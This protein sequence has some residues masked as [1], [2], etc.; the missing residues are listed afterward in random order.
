MLYARTFIF[1]RFC[2]HFFANIHSFDMFHNISVYV[3]YFLGIL[4]HS[5]AFNICSDN[6][7]FAYTAIKDIVKKTSI[8]KL[9]IV[10]I[11]S[12]KF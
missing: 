3:I 12:L 5:V 6:L 10:E 11:S 9:D 2:F 8:W 1:L 7:A 4:C